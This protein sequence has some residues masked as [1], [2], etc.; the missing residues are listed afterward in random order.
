MGPRPGHLNLYND[1]DLPNPP[2]PNFYMDLPSPRAGEVPPALSPLDAFALH[3]RMLARK[4]EEEAN[5]GRR[6]SRIPPTSVAS[7]L[8]RR[9][10]YFRSVSG[11][12]GETML[13]DMPSLQEE[14]RPGT[15]SGLQVASS[16]DRPMSH[17]PMLGNARS[18]TPGGRPLA[19]PDEWYDAEERGKTEVQ[20]YFG[21]GVPRASSPEPVDPRNVT[22][23]APSPTVPSLTSSIDSVS[24]SQPRTMTNE[25]TGSQRLA[26]GLAPPRS[27]AFPK[28]PRSM[29]SIRSVRADS[30]DEDGSSI[31]GSYGLAQSSRKFSGSSGMSRPQSPFSPFMRPVHRSPS[32]TSEYSINGSQLQRPSFNFSRPMSSSGGR[33]ST[34]TCPSLDSRPSYENRPS[35]E[36]PIRHGSNSTHPSSRSGLSRQGSQD[37]AATPYAHLAG[38]PGEAAEG[39]DYFSGSGSN[40]APSYIYTKYS[41]PRGR[42][43]ERNSIGPRES[44]L[45]YQFK[46]DEPPPQQRDGAT[47][48]ACARTASPAHSEKLSPSQ[49][50]QTREDA[51]SSFNRSRSAG[52]RPVDQI[53]IQHRSNP[54]VPAS[55]I[56][57]STDRTVRPRSPHQKTP[58]MELTPEEHLEIGIQSHSSG[59][60]SKS[61]YH[62]RLA[63]KAGLP[64][65][66]LLYALACRHGWG[67]RPNQEEGV[68]WLRKAIDGSGLEVSN[69]E[70]QL[71]ASRTPKEN[72]ADEAAERRKRKAQFALAIYELGI[73]YMNGW[74][75]PKDKSLAL[76]CFE[77][78]GNWGDCDALA[79]AG[80]CYTQGVGCKKDLKKAAAL[81]RKAADGGMSMAGNSWY[82]LSRDRSAVYRC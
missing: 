52:P 62:L 3:S 72:S 68:A 29:A 63:A 44:W 67:M 43:V 28:S 40:P 21:I 14:E 35:T 41:L 5:N 76:R 71:A 30:G 10:T 34:D 79:E 47:F 16:E 38:T 65:A 39:D 53:E 46:W 57:A 82:V 54:S 59:A 26:Y 33:P 22:V 42:T 61:T 24:S 36:L 37:S 23:E 73:S 74:G 60:L 12:S 81:Y 48:E 31:G 51:G 66:M 8:A 56:S 15:R 11:E 55:V 1:N 64:T 32:M 6:I 2:R 69:V 20:D 49:E 13:S 19:T 75:I 77:I 27:P 50:R 18:L 80:F 25:S 70:D 4:F 17:Y 9:P 78:A 45:Q 7:E 58:S